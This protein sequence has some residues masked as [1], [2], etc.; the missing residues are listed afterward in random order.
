[1]TSPSIVRNQ[2]Q[3]FLRLWQSVHPHVRTD[4]DLPARLQT[5]CAR[6]GFGARDRRLYRELLYTAVRD[7]PWMEELAARAERRWSGALAWLAADAPATD[8]FRSALAA[9][10]PECPASVSGRARVLGVGRDLMPGRFFASTVPRPL[11]LP[12]WTC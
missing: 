7:L 5:S 10:W 11:S 12:I 4:R 2:Q 6:R 9:D 3:T 8:G 1:M